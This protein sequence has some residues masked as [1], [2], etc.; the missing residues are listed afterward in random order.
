M[1]AAPI[2]SAIVGLCLA[3]CATT[4]GSPDLLPMRLIGP[5]ESWSGELTRQGVSITGPQGVFSNE[6]EDIV[7]LSASPSMIMMNAEVSETDYVSVLLTQESCAANGRN[8][9]Y[10]AYFGVRRT[11]EGGYVLRG[12]AE[13]SRRVRGR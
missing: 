9:A 12:C 13:P 10:S 1:R 5:D 2:L 4:G 8:Y 6:P 11:V 3:G 7:H